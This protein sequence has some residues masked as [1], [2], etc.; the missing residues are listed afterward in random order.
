MSASRLLGSHVK[1]GKQALKAEHRPLL[2]E[3]KAAKVAR[4]VDFE[5][6]V[7]GQMREYKRW[8]YFIETSAQSDVIHGVEVHQCKWEELRQKRDDT[9]AILNALCPGTSAKI[10]TWQVL[11]KGELPR[12]DHLARFKADTRIEL[13]RNLEISKLT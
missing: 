7:E 12:R 11:V 2:L 13:C 5:K 4:S 10:K 1:V 3:T 8:D 6:A 9:V